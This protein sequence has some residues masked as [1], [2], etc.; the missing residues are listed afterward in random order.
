MSR[1]SSDILRVM[2]LAIG[3][4]NSRDPDSTD[5]LLLQ[6]VNDFISL[7]MSDEFKIFEQFRTLS[8]VIDETTTDGV[9]SFPSNDTSDD[10]IN[11]TSEVMASL[12][13]PVGS[14]VSWYSLNLYQDPGEFY[15][16]W[17]VNNEDV[18]IAG[19]PT[20]VLYH[21]NEFVFRTIP[22]DSYTIKM[23][24]YQRVSELSTGNSTLPYDYWMRFVAYGAA[25]QYAADYRLDQE[26]L[27][28]IERNYSR[29][30]NLLMK[31][32]HNQIKTQRSYP[33]F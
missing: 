26:A 13:D 3:R 33:R 24:G 7:T 2:R 8:F 23:Y 28:N 16:Y 4:R 10:F 27:V 18:L 31:R 30:R 12:T 11:I 22:N 29:E 20:D 17:G 15:S 25:K 14:S 9:Y 5:D 1:S 19:Q 6:Y 32:T 21:G